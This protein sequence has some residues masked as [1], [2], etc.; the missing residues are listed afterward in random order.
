MCPTPGVISDQYV[1]LYESLARGGPGL[2]ITG[3][4]SVHALGVVQGNNLIL[5]SDDVIP[6]LSRVTA[7]VKRHGVPIFA[8]VSHGGRYANRAF[9]GA[10]PI[11]P[12]AVACLVD[13]V[14]PR[15]MTEE[16]IEIAIEAFASAAR[17]IQE[18][19]FDGMEINASHG[20]LV[21]QFLSGFTN[22]R[23]DRWGGSAFNRLRFLAEIIARSRASVGTSFPIS[24]KLNGSDFMRRGNMIEDTV[25][26]AH[27]LELLGVSGLTVS[28]GFKERPFRTMSRGDIP[29]QLILAHKK[30]VEKTVARV[31]LAAMRRGA[32]FSEGYFLPQAAAIKRAVSIPVTVVGGFRTL[33][34]MEQAL[35]DGNADLIGLSRPFIRE[36]HLARRLQ[37]GKAQAATCLNCNRC[38]VTTGMLSQPLRCH[39]KKD[40]EA[41]TEPTENGVRSQALTTS[42]GFHLFYR[43]AKPAR[44]RGAVFF[45]HGMSEH[46]GMYLHV[47]SALADEGFV[48]IAPDQRGRGRSVDRQWRRGDLH[49]MARVLQ[50]LDE[51]R[52][53]CLSDCQGLPTFIVGVSMGSIIAQMYALRR[54]PSL[55]GVLLVGPPFGVPA[56][57]SPLLVRISSVMAV[58]TPRLAMRPAPAIE[59][60]SRV[61]A[62]QNELDWDP[63]CYHGPLRA[64][65]ARELVRSLTELRLRIGE[66][67]LP[68]LTLYGTGDRIVSR[69]E[70]EDIHRAWGGHDRTLVTM[71]GLFHDVLNEPEN[72]AALRTMVDWLVLRS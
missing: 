38:T 4:F 3:N 57:T 67:A 18:A 8:Q 21:N 56:G 34:F 23:M 33:A 6:Q 40:A 19:G 13:R 55:A 25:F 68:L 52:E 27:E 22:R 36:P 30:G 7:A 45:L 72:Q 39:W 42:D 59:N 20:Y 61:R 29:Q 64:R 24:V 54:Q 11:A 32:R 44:P 37:E 17:R 66:I 35:L 10:H 63:W 70:V 50:D 2:I 5:D 47:L 71:D 53:K 16:E 48:V 14:T 31:L 49:S 28:G 12:S 62:F 69:G 26:F 43:L 58:A 51:L 9:T 41:E 1:R 15:P 60:I 65:A 46:S